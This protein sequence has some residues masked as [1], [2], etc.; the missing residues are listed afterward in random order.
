M[1]QNVHVRAMSS[2]AQNVQVQAMSELMSGHVKMT[3]DNV[4]D[5]T[6]MSG[7]CNVSMHLLKM[8]QTQFH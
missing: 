2:L 7:Q 3:Q 6:I 4:S 1:A 5:V 8:K